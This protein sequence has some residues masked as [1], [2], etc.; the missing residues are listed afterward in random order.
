MAGKPAKAEPKEVKTKDPTQIGGS[1]SSAWNNILANQAVQ[2]LW[3]C[4]RGARGRGGEI[5]T[6]LEGSNRPE[7]ETRNAA[8]W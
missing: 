1:K 8:N 3:I 6:A 7:S 4:W 5:S 2:T